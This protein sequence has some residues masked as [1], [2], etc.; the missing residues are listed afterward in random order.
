MDKQHTIEKL[1]EDLECFSA[2]ESNWQQ[3]ET[4]YKSELQQQ[5]AKIAQIQEE[6]STVST[7]LKLTN[8]V[9]LGYFKNINFISLYFL[10]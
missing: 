10:C 3:T 4:K 5:Q 6:L 9:S 7:E 1:K 2:K 8:M